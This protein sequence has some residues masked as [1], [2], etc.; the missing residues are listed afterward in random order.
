LTPKP[1]DFFSRVNRKIFWIVAVI[2]I[3]ASV[4]GYTYCSKVFLAA[5]A[6]GRSAVQTAAAPLGDGGGFQQH[7]VTLHRKLVY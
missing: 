4:R 1:T 7:A 5:P 2:I 3:L 6:T